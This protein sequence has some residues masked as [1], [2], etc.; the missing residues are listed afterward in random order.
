M[1][2]LNSINRMGESMSDERVILKQLQ[3][4]AEIIELVQRYAQGVDARDMQALFDCFVEDAVVIFHGGQLT[5]RG[6]SEVRG[7]FSSMFADD[8]P[9]RPTNRSTHIMSNI[10]V[11]L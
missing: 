5:C 1:P 11:T 9:L 4:K 8:G 7:F 3:D 2:P 6:H 10:L